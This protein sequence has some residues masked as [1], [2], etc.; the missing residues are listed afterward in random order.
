MAWE[1]RIK[2]NYGGSLKNLIFRGLTKKPI[3]SGGCLKRRAWTVCRFKRG[4]GEKEG[5]GVFK[6]DRGRTG[7]GG[8]GRDNQIH[9][10]WS[11]NF[12]W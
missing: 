3:C 12:F 1:L 9:T 7:V 2:K 5:E 8:G 6:G 11:H 10:I 4:I